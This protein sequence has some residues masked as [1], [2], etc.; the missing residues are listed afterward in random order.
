[1]TASQTSTDAFYNREYDT[2][3][4]VEGLDAL[5]ADWAVRNEAA[6][7]SLTGQRDLAYG[8]GDRERLD[9]YP[10][11][12]G[13]PLLVFIHGGFWHSRTKEDFLFV[14]PPFVER[15][16]SVAMIEYA[17]APNV[18][19]T[20]ITDQ[21]R[22]A[23]AFLGRE[24]NN[25]GL[26]TDRMLVSGHSAGGHLAAFSACDTTDTGLPPHPVL[27]ISG[28]F[29]LAPIALAPNVQGKLHLSPD[30]I[31]TLSPIHLAPRAGT[32]L[33]TTVGGAETN[34]FRRQNTEFAAAWA[35]VHVGDVAQPGGNH[36]TALD[37]LSQPGSDVFEAAMD[38]LELP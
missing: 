5:F 25:L 23:L 3:A 21:V 34:E 33:I 9:F 35:S 2:R 24:A 19:L 29:D 20:T 11:R 14:A 7:S 6:Q 22:R 16:I 1:M 10:G 13:A 12:P 38:L 17:L 27:A 37:T 28:L 30:E 15:G 4:G 26:R 8:T 32:R 31:A 36:F 18:S